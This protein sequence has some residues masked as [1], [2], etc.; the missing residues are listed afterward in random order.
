MAADK[1]AT[2]AAMVPPKHCAIGH[3]D[4]PPPW[5]G[6]QYSLK[7]KEASKPNHAP[8]APTGIA[9]GDLI[10]LAAKAPMRADRRSRI[11]QK[12]TAH[13]RAFGAY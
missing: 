7:S 8:T 6:R 11:D 1:P 2:P 5:Y 10:N 9:K 12:S 3:I 4:A 13:L